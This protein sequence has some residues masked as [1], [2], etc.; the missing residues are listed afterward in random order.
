LQE[1]MDRLLDERTPQVQ[2]AQPARRRRPAARG[3][4][5]SQAVASQSTD[6]TQAAGSGSGCA[7]M[8]ASEAN[9]SDANSGDDDDVGMFD[10]EDW[11][12]DPGPA[13]EQVEVVDE[14]QDDFH[15]DFQA[16][17][18]RYQQTEVGEEIERAEDVEEEDDGDVQDDPLEP[19]DVWSEDES[20]SECDDDVVGV[21]GARSSSASTSS[22]DVGAGH[23]CTIC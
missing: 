4:A 13:I 21:G 10:D 12:M 20:G 3:G 11:D 2:P 15:D 14:A 7:T 17:A 19:L 5:T 9:D 16:L 23:D 8:E 22:G 18:M 6:P 1:R